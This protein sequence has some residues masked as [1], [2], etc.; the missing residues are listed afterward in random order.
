MRIAARARAR[1]PIAAMAIAWAWAGA[2]SVPASAAPTIAAAASRTAAPVAAAAAPG[3][4][5]HL[6][7]E[8]AVARALEHGVDLRLADAG[9]SIANGRVREALAAAFPQV[10]GSLTYGRKFDSIFK[11]AEGDTLIGSLFKNSPFA[12][13]HSWT[14]DITASQLIWSGGRLG[15]GLAAARAAR[16]STHANRDETAALVTREV[17][18]AYL[19]AAYASQLLAIAEAGLSQARAHMNEVALYQR[20][21][22]RAEYDL[23]RAQVDAANQ[24]P[25][26]VGARNASQ[27]AMLELK[28][29]MSV[30]LDRPVA[31]DTPLAFEAG[32]VPVVEDE[33]LDAS[34]R[35]LI[36]RAEADVEARRQLVRFERAARWPQL[37]L[38]GTLSEQAFPPTER[39]RR[40]EFRRD[41]NASLKL[42]FPLFLGG[43][44]FG[45]VQRATAELRQAEAERDRIR[46]GSNVEVE[47]A[48]QEVRRTLAVLAARRGTAQLSQRAHHLANVRYTNGIA[49]QL[50]VSDARLQMLTAET[51]EVQATRDYLAALVDLEYAVGHPLR[52]R[53]TPLSEI[54][55]NLEDGADDHAHR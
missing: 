53:G 55:T 29:L 12:A 40:D 24:E 2:V 8:Q 43:R 22:V 17:R 38:S 48:R 5:L 13:V 25:P 45:A 1:L 28:R 33:T 19:D 20:Q 41:L 42:E 36:A 54:A 31:L 14:A 39:P 4:T 51:N 21:G 15:A 37:T 11:S 26:V 9:I 27:I 18:K 6:T 34:K 44:T 49:T 3:D 50:E 35:A 30:A 46:D 52:T 32:M 7:I 16:R 23:I 47:R 10:N